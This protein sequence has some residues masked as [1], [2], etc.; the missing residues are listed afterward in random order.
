T[1]NFDEFIELLRDRIE[2]V[3]LSDNNGTEDSHLA[4]GDGTVPWKEI[5]K[6]VPRVPMSLE[7]K[8]FDGA[9]KSLKFLKELRGSI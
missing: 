1:G 8:T 9:I 4:L 6:K 3:H 2:Y 5:M 7:V